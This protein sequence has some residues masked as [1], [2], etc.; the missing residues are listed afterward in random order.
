MI[1]IISN[2]II[3]P[4]SFLLVQLFR[5]SRRRTTRSVLLKK[6]IANFVEQDKKSKIE[7][8]GKDQLKKSKKIKPRLTFPWWFKRI[9][10]ILS[11]LFASVSIVFIIFKGITF[12]DEKCGKWLSSFF[13]SILSSCFLTQPLQVILL[14]FSKIN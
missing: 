14:V 3:F 6:K 11:F 9:A 13:I 4:P 1:G 12:G 5:R 10:Y 8:I 2:L 7:M